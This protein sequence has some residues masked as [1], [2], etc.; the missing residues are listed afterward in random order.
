MFLDELQ[1]R[2]PVILVSCLSV[3]G[4]L[5]T[6]TYC[7]VLTSPDIRIAD[8]ILRL[9]IMW[10][11]FECASFRSWNLTGKSLSLPLLDFAEQLLEV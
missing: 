1:D 6:F 3:Q 8:V 5:Y 2:F 9:Y 10:T 7:F 4:N 11:I